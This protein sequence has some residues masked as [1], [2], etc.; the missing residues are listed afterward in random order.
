MLFMSLILLAVDASA[1]MVHHE[2]RAILVDSLRTCLASAST[3]AD[4][5][6]IMFDLYDLSTIDNNELASKELYYVAKR[7]GD[8]DAQLEMLRNIALLASTIKDEEMG[9]W[10]LKEVATL[11]PSENRSQSTVFIKACIADAIQFASEEERDRYINHTLDKF[12]D[13]G[14]RTVDKYERASQLFMLLNLLSGDR[15]GSMVEDYA[16]QLSSVIL[17]MPRLPV[18]YLL[19]RQNTMTA[20]AFWHNDMFEQSVE[21][22]RRQ[23]ESYDRMR[24]YNEQN[25]RSYCNYALQRYASIARMMRSYDALSDSE[26]DSLAAEVDKICEYYPK[27]AMFHDLRPVVKMGQL[28]KKGRYDEAMPIVKTLTE[29]AV[30]LDEKRH[31]L[32][33]LAYVA[34][35]VGDEETKMQ[36]ESELSRLIAEYELNRTDQRL[37]EL[38]TLYE[39]SNR[40]HQTAEV[41]LERQNRRAMEITVVSIILALT[42]FVFV[43]LYMRF[44]G[45]SKKLNVTNEALK[46]DRASLLN[47]QRKLVEARDKARLAETEKSQIITYISNELMGPANAV[48]EYAHMLIDS[49]PAEQNE[50]MRRFVDVISGNTRIIQTI[51]FDV[52][53]F[54]TI[55]T[56]RLS[57]VCEPV[58]A[59]RMAEMAVESVRPGLKS[60]L[61]LEMIPVTDGSPVII[62]DSRRVESILLSLLS[63]AIKFTDKGSVTL[64]VEIDRKEAKATFSV[65]DTG[66]GVPADKAEQI[67]ERF[68]RL[69]S[70]R[71]G[72][73]LGLANCRMIA[74]ALNGTVSL[75]TS[76]PGPGSRFLLI[77]P[78]D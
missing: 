4:S 7:L 15:H 67:F 59:N 78:I 25:G 21:A 11:P 33:I 31:Y 20:I 42:L 34:D 5:F 10:T 64:K 56:H 68:E 18:N 24:K 60:G 23:L 46:A 45:L 69:N 8:E 32:R 37:K 30:D 6:R 3:T 29:N 47:A 36:S 12:V 28:M 44:R 75:D 77:I 16:N 66:I 17:S 2:E 49:L 72:L 26:V 13:V 51:A 43:I 9:R 52:Q 74:A 58:D 14:N 71:V 48:S 55:E 65:T 39:L 62:T 38:H 27:Y 57:T 22:D 76:Y 41:A 63:N 40:R 54:S 19:N 1:R 70:E 50:V 73:G 35:K 61:S 53:E